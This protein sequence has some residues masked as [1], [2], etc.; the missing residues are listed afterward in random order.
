MEKLTFKE[1]QQWLRENGWYTLWNE[2]NWLQ[3]Y[4]TYA[5][6][7]WEG[8]STDRAYEYAITHPKRLKKSSTTPILDSFSKDLTKLAKEKHIK[9]RN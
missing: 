7:D 3:R 6:P 5:N 9:K 2:D 4:E 8:M 1:K